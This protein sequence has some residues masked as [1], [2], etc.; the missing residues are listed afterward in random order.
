MAENPA[1]IQDQE[2]GL[3]NL[4]YDPAKGPVVA[5]WASWAAYYWTNGLLG[6]S[7]GLTWSCQDNIADGVHPATSGRLKAAALLLNFLKT[8]DAAIPWY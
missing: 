2:S 7:D 1:V 6:R 4:N 3:G 8:D 5:P